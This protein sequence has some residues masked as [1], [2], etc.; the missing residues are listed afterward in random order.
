M[1]YLQFEQFLLL[2]PTTGHVLLV[3]QMCFVQQALFDDF[4]WL[5]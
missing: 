2:H 1:R 3:F 4:D 5:F